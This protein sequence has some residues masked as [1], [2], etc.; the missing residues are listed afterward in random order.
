VSISY[1][2][3]LFVALLL[4][5]PG[6]TVGQPIVPQFDTG[7]THD[8]GPHD[9]S[10]DAF[11]PIDGGPD[12]GRD[13]PPPDVFFTG[14][15]ACASV[16][17]AATL[18]REPADIIWVIDN[19]GS[20]S[21]SITAVREGLNHFADELAASDLDYR[22]IMLASRG[23]AAQSICVPEPLAG[24]ACADNPPNFYQIDVDILSTQPIEQIIGTLAQTPGY[25][26]ADTRG[27]PPWQNLLRPGATRTFVLVSDDN[28]RTNTTFTAT[29]LEDYPGGPSP[30]NSTTLGPGI[31]TA[32]YGDLFMGYTFDAIYSWGGSGSDP[33][34]NPTTPCGTGTTYG[35]TYTTLVA[36][37][38]GIRAR[39]CDGA[40]AFTPFF[41]AIAASVV[42]G[43]PISCNLTIP[44]APTGMTFQSNRVNVVV[45][46]RGGDTLLPYVPNMA[47]CDAT[48]GGWYYD[49][50]P[51]PTEV[52]LCPT[53]CTSAQMEVVGAGTGLDVQFGCQSVLM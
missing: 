15:T 37:T 39:I 13:A 8:G 44:P 9:A 12:V 21:S 50:L 46:G 30:F 24:P 3:C 36:R 42:S 19:S 5:G 34:A 31:L 1:P 43:S 20:M 25:T 22:V 4:C 40:A 18:T 33:L 29:A 48:R 17:Q 32:G 53:S 41:D 10:M 35:A 7:S 45:H 51:N 52:I 38:G 47:A 49:T 2:R 28:Q 26:M 16:A 11:V 23:T 14:D 6:C 27:G